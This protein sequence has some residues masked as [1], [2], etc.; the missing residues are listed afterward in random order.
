MKKIKDQFGLYKHWEQIAKQQEDDFRLSALRE[1][2]IRSG[3]IKRHHKIL[4]LGC[5]TCDLTAALLSTKYN[6]TS[7]D[8]SNEMLLIGKHILKQKGLPTNKVFRADIKSF[9]KSHR[10]TYDIIICL[11]VIEHIENDIDALM[12]IN[13]LLKPGGI[14]ILTVPAL[15]Y[16]YGPKDEAI[17]HYRRYNRNDVFLKLTSAGFFVSKIRFWNF[18]GVFPTFISVKLLNKRL[19][20][21]F[22]YDKSFGKIILQKLLKQWFRLVENNFSFNLGLTLFTVSIKA[23]TSKT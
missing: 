6:V 4:D 9:S 21:N 15:S 2:I 1:L 12:S 17:G 10:N 16:L 13:Y 20:E 5:G 23:R 22:R 18:I 19:D 3:L 14:L 11:D 7:V 8:I